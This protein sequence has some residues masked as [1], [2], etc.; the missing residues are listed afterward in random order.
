M[1]DYKR[2]CEKSLDAMVDEYRALKAI[3]PK[4]PGIVK[5]EEDIRELIGII[6][7]MT[8][9]CDSA[10]YYENKCSEVFGS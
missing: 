3:G 10:R 8:E 9:F 1:E 6:A 7:D 2:T 4:S 5:M